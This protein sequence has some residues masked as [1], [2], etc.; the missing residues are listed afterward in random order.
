MTKTLK[1]VIGNVV[2]QSGKDIDTHKVYSMLIAVGSFLFLF[3]VFYNIFL[4]IILWIAFIVYLALRGII[5]SFM[6]PSILNDSR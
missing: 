5:Q 3:W 1:N 6:A 2:K 4:N